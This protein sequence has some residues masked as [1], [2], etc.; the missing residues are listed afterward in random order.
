MGGGMSM[1]SGEEKIVPENIEKLNLEWLWRLRTNTWFRLK[2]LVT[3]GLSFV[4]KTIFKYFKKT[5]FK[6]IDQILLIKSEVIFLI[7]YF[8]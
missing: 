4:F 2:R 3:T 6:S 1:V 5:T 8:F 7:E